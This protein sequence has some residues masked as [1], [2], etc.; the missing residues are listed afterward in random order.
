MVTGPTGSGRP[1]LL[2]ALL[3]HIHT[4]TKNIVTVEDP[5]EYTIAGINQVQVEEKSKKTFSNIL[6]AML[7]QDPDIMMI[8]EVRD[9]ETAQIAFAP[10]S[11][12]T[13]SSRRCTPTTRPPRS[14]GSST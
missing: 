8:G 7:R 2:Y 10:R 11:R 9:L 12:A 13:S 6:R 3:Q 1:T 14:P 4:V 5:I